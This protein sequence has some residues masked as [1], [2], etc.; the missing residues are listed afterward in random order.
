MTSTATKDR[1]LGKGLAALLGQPLDDDG[2]PLTEGP[3]ARIQSLELNVSE[4]EANPFQPR[5]EF[6]PDEIASLAESIKNHQQLQPILVRIVDGKYQLC[7]LYT[8]PSPRDAT[9]SRMP[10]SA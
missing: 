9:L 2:N 10:S 8:S 3:G 6:N 1:R 7:L 4:I 5:R